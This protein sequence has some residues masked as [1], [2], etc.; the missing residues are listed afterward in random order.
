MIEP[1]KKR[2]NPISSLP[3]EARLHQAVGARRR[4]QS[5]GCGWGVV[6]RWVG[7]VCVCVCV[8]FVANPLLSRGCEVRV[9]VLWRP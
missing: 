2:A 1:L 4:L 3:A 9:M 7:C 5:A 8:M 6:V